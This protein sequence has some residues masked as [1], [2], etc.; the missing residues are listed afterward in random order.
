MAQPFII[1]ITGGSGSGKTTFI[2]QLR[3]GLSEDQVCY[4][5]MDDYYKPIHDQRK[6]ENGIENFD[7]PW[8]IYKHEFVRDLRL[9]MEGENGDAPGVRL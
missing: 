9:L 2:Q 5:S 4:L 6:D 8:S 3:E 1:G 7:I